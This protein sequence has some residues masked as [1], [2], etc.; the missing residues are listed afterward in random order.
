MTTRGAVLSLA[1]TMTGL[2]TLGSVAVA[3]SSPWL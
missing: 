3:E 2:V 1:L